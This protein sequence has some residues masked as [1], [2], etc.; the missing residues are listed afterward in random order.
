MDS[1]SPQKTFVSSQIF[2]ISTSFDQLAVSDNVPTTVSGLIEISISKNIKCD[3][4]DYPR[5]L[6]LLLDCSA[7]MRGIPYA[8]LLASVQFL[9]EYLNEHQRVSVITFGEVSTIISNLQPCTD[10]LKKD[11]LGKLTKK[12]LE[13]ATDI[14]AAFKDCKTV[15]KNSINPII[16]LFT[17]GVAN[18][19]I[20]TTDELVESLKTCGLS[21]HTIHCFGYGDEHS[22]VMLDAISCLSSNGL[23]Y[24]ILQESDI[25]DKIGPFIQRFNNIIC[26]DTE[27]RITPSEGVSNI[28]FHSLLKI[29]K[30]ESANLYK[31]CL[32]EFSTE[33]T[34]VI[35]FTVITNP[36]QYK[37]NLM[38]ISLS[39]LNL[40]NNSI[41]SIKDKIILPVDSESVSNTSDVIK[42][43][44]EEKYR[45][46]TGK[47]IKSRIQHSISIE[48]INKLI[49]EMENDNNDKL[50]DLIKQLKKFTNNRFSDK[51]GYSLASTH[52][53]RQANTGTDPRY[54]SPNTIAL[55]NHATNYI[56]TTSATYMDINSLKQCL[57]D[58]DTHNDNDD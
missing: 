27:L 20:T 12:T 15:V 54:C 10:N 40:Q 42:L 13:R 7:S 2:D 47:Y 50:T 53:T 51:A 43:I 17:D 26:N 1:T 30:K 23:Y 25:G 56:R 6:I 3:S 8:Y 9:F 31:I 33:D 5:D 21:Q 36:K 38:T 55:S 49:L 57:V 58:T 41:V 48:E 52:R 45:Y 37:N 32:N 22:P 46:L 24:N 18:T 35:L 4:T 39:Y 14:S 19:G 16:A 44:K 11:I 28:N 29:K 34:T